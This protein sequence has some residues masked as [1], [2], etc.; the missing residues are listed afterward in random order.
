VFILTTGQSE[1]NPL[2]SGGV[3]SSPGRLNLKPLEDLRVEQ[4]EHDHLLQRLD[5]ITEAAHV[6]EFH[7]GR[8]T[9]ETHTHTHTHTHTLVQ[10]THFDQWIFMTFP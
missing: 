6:V 8:E 4:R 10:F 2:M 5:V 3:F 1:R 9:R 7:L